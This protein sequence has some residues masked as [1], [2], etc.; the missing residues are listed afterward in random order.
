MFHLSKLSLKLSI[1]SVHVSGVSASRLFTPTWSGIRPFSVAHCWPG[2]DL[3]N[4]GP[5]LGTLLALTVRPGPHRTRQRCSGP[6]CDRP[7]VS[8]P[9]P[10]S[11]NASSSERGAFDGPW[12]ARKAA[13]SA[14]G[15]GEDRASADW[16]SFTRTTL[17]RA[18]RAEGTAVTDRMRVRGR[19]WRTLAVFVICGY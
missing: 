11:Q 8:R 16:V 5:R 7:S 2:H 3:V 18:G 1:C 10:S 4:K 6:V 9:I 12:P 17:Y 19:P 15:C 13:N 14:D